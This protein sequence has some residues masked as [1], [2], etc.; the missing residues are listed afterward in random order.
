MKFQT[1]DIR[2]CTVIEIA[3]LAHADDQ[4]CTTQNKKVIRYIRCC[5]I[6]LCIHISILISDNDQG[7]LSLAS[8]IRVGMQ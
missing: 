3:F 1:K 2:F 8:L 6:H 4:I 5:Y 7:N